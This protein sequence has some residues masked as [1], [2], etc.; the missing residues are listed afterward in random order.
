MNEE[1]L[2]RLDALAAKLGATGSDLFNIMVAEAT[3]AGWV[4]TLLGVVLAIV[5]IRVALRVDSWDEP[6]PQCVVALALGVA[7]VITVPVL[8]SLG[9][10]RLLTPTTYVL[11]GIF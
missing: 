8:L 4:L 10:E 7:S 3:T 2:K 11:H 9:L 5:A 1:T 6:K